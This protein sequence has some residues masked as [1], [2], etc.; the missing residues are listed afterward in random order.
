MLMLREELLEWDARG[1]CGRVDG[2]SVSF[3]NAR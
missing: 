3:K 1:N 2:V